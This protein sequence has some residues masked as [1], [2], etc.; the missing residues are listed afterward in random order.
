MACLSL[1]QQN[2]VPNGSFEDITG[3]PEGPSHAYPNQLSLSKNWDYP[4]IGSSDLYVDCSIS[5]IGGVGVPT[6]FHGYQVPLHGSAYAGF[7]AFDISFNYSEYVRVSLNESVKV[8]DTLILN[9]YVSLSNRSTHAVAKLGASLE[10]SETGTSAPLQID[11]D[12]T[13]ELSGY[14]AD[15]AGWM[16]LN[17][18]IIAN[19]CGD[20]LTIGYFSQSD[21]DTIKIQNS[22]NGVFSNYYLDSVSLIRLNN[23]ENKLSIPNVFS[24]NNDGIGDI[25]ELYALGEISVYNRWGQLIYINKHRIRWDGK[26]ADGDYVPEGTYY[27]IIKSVESN[28]DAHKYY[29]GFVQVFR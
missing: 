2:L 26:N 5:S 6:N 24:P 17:D 20:Y 10:N 9:C 25:F 8:G 4:A 13:L 21:H 15:T 7:N 28:C 3:C 14:L 29:K 1:G 12:F 11:P 16:K 23:S 27:Y 18:T 19:K 22:N